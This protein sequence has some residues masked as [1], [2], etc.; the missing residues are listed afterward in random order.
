MIMTEKTIALVAMA[1]A[2]EMLLDG[3]DDVDQCVINNGY[4]LLDPDSEEDIM[5]ESMLAQAVELARQVC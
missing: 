3:D 1:I 5:L 4:L 2:E